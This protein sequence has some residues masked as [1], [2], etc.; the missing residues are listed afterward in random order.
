MNVKIFIAKQI[1][2]N[3]VKAPLL[4]PDEI[5][6][7]DVLHKMSCIN[8]ARSWYNNLKKYD[9]QSKYKKRKYVKGSF[10]NSCFGNQYYTT[11]DWRVQGDTNIIVSLNDTE[12]TVIKIRKAN[13]TLIQS[14]KDLSLR[15]SKE[16]ANSCGSRCGDLWKMFSLGE[17]G[18]DEFSL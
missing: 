18:N 10:H 1:N 8:D 12:T 2:D 17:K 9:H 11:I 4:P 15:L 5:T 16:N 13:K 7:N 3:D 14:M 6:H